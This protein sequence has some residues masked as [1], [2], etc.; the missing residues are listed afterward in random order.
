VENR[1]SSTLTT[2]DNLTNLTTEEKAVKQ[3]RDSINQKM[4]TIFV[5]KKGHDMKYMP[6]TSN[7][8]PLKLTTKDSIIYRKFTTKSSGLVMPVSHFCGNN[9]WILKPT[10]LNR[11]KGIHVV[12]SLK[13]LKRL[14]KEYVRGRAEIGPS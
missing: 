3:A 8:T 2:D 11:G 9:V 6:Q 13:K 1:P 4:M 7:D 12:S 5:T 10:G 14:I